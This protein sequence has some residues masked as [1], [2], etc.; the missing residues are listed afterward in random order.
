MQAFVIHKSSSIHDCMSLQRAEGNALRWES[1]R[2]SS[3]RSDQRRPLRS[4]MAGDSASTPFRIARLLAAC[5]SGNQ[6]CSLR[7]GR[8][9]VLFLF[10]LQSPLRKQSNG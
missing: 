10:E 2:S 1:A 8:I 5:P 6:A 3:P 7:R 9:D 4:G